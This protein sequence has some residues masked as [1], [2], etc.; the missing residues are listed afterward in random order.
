MSRAPTTIEITEYARQLY[1]IARIVSDGLRKTKAGDSYRFIGSMNDVE[2]LREV[3]EI[4]SNPDG[5]IS[6]AIYPPEPEDFDFNGDE[7]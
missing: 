7:E 5:P 6:T 3:L 2:D 1:K 4:A